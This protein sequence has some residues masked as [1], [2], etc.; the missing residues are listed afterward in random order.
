LLTLHSKELL[1]N[2]ILD[3][4]GRLPFLRLQIC[5]KHIVDTG[6]LKCTDKLS[7]PG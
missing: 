4:R 7:R 1:K 3:N 6:T 5:N 2:E